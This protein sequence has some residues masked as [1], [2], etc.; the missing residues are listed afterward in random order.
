MEKS[1]DKPE[2]FITIDKK[3]LSTDYPRSTKFISPAINDSVVCIIYRSE[4]KNQLRHYNIHG[5]L[6][7]SRDFPKYPK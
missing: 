1:N 3:T 5:T 4:Q 7:W 6:L 2:Q